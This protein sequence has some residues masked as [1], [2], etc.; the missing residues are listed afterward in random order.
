MMHFAVFRF[1]HAISIISIKCIMCMKSFILISH[2]IIVGALTLLTI[3]NNIESLLFGYY[4]ISVM[5]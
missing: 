3:A 2:I 5:L 1:T 4:H